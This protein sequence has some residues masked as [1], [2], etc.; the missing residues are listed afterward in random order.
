[1]TPTPP[2]PVK[3]SWRRLCVAC[4]GF[5]CDRYQSHA[6]VIPYDLSSPLQALTR[7]VS[8]V[9]ISAAPRAAGTRP[10]RESPPPPPPSPLLASFPPL[11]TQASLWPV[12]KEKGTTERE[13]VLPRW[14]SRTSSPSSPPHIDRSA[15]AVPASSSAGGRAGWAPHRPAAT[16]PVGHHSRAPSAGK[17]RRVT[18]H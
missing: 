15:A 1:M 18:R 4:R 8:P 16:A 11:P 7:G 3:N 17:E 14:L 5:G 2:P 10:H 6:P 12:E 13:A 9:K